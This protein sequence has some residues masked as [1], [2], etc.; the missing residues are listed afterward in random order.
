MSLPDDDKLF[1]R[2][3]KVDTWVLEENLNKINQSLASFHLISRSY[4]QS[5][6]FSKNNQ[7]AIQWNGLAQMARVITKILKNRE[8]EQKLL[9]KLV[10][11]ATEI[12]FAKLMLDLKNNCDSQK[13][14]I[15]RPYS[16]EISSSA[17]VEFYS[18]CS[19]DLLPLAQSDL[20]RR[21]SFAK[22][23]NFQPEELDWWLRCY[24]AQQKAIQ[25][26]QKLGIKHR[27]S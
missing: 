24:E 20:A 23:L 21:I 13:E 19:A 7:D 18:K 9:G 16:R 4:P 8:K 25:E 11:N 10:E 3:S 17:F 22:T 27:V 14:K 5:G 26:V 6:F 1:E 2:L 12:E 15:A